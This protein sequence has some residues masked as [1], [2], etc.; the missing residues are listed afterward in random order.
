ML[1]RSAAGRAIALLALAAAMILCRAARGEAQPAASAGEPGGRAAEHA[2]APPGPRPLPP[3]PGAG[4][5]TVVAIAGAVDLGL[6]PFLARVVAAQGEGDLLVLDINTLGGRVDAALAIRDALLRARGRTI[7]WVNP[8]AISA[9]ALIALACDAI[10]VAPGATIGAATPVQIGEGGGMQ[11]V[12]EKVVSY[13]RKEMRATAEAKGRRGDIAEAMVDA[14]VEVPG[15]DE[16]GKLL[17]LDGAQALAWGFA[18]VQAGSEAELFRALGRAPPGEIARPRPSVAEELARFLSDPAFAGI[19]M[20]LG[21]LGVL[22][23]LYSPGHGVSLAVGFTC[24]ALFFF[25]HHVV[26]LAGWEEI[27]LFVAGAV[28]IAVEIFVPGHVAPGVAGALCVAGALILALI[29]LERVPVDVA[30]HAGWLPRALASVSVSLAAT[31]ALAVVAARLAP[32]TRLGRRLVLDA[33]IRGVAVGAPSGGAAAPASRVG[34]IG[35]AATDL[36][37]S[38]K[39]V[40]DGRRVEALSELGYVEAGTRVRVIRA[41]AGRVVVRALGS[42]MD[43]NAGEEGRA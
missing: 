26:K 41:D 7:C 23:E 14:D 1:G 15:L 13:M 29:D 43:D 11:P 24:L 28:L 27:A 31:A 32:R 37:P 36:R 39:V 6:S 8:R 33:A 42:G 38:G 35:A 40:L 22:L 12:A 10:A 25:G 2:P 19:L 3:I 18:E 16:K 34:Q 9:G 5:V 21:M 20:T 17:T 30:W 4:R